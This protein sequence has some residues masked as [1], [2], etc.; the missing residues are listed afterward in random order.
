MNW[1]RHVLV[2]VALLVAALPCCHAHEHEL[3]APDTHAP[4]ELTAA[5][6]CCCHSCDATLCVDELEMPQELTLPA[7]TV[8]SPPPA[9]TLMVFIESKPAIPPLP[10]RRCDDLASL[11]TVQLLI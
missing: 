1:L 9:I 2:T 4:T 11:Q 7:A 8:A 5:H 3:R 10:P 6:H